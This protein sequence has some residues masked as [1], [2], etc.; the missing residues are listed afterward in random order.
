MTDEYMIIRIFHRERPNEIVRRGL[1]KEQALEHVNGNR[2][3][4]ARGGGWF[5]AFTRD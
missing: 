5:D 1:T 3:S 4:G 2:S